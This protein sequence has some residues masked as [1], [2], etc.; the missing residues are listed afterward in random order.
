MPL[1]AG[2]P[3][4]LCPLRLVTAGWA[5]LCRIHRSNYALLKTAVMTFDKAPAFLEPQIGILALTE[6][7]REGRSAFN[8][9]RKPT[10]TGRRPSRRFLS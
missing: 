9:V 1:G 8:E 7:A 5:A 2:Y 10:S 6:D 3:Q 4:F